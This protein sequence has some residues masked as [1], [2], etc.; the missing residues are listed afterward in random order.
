MLRGRMTTLDLQIETEVR[1]RK[2]QGISGDA[3]YEMVDSA[4]EKRHSSGGI[5][6]DV[7]CGSGHLWR[8]VQTRFARYVGVDIVRYEGF[9]PDAEFH[10]LNLDTGRV[11]LPDGCADVVAAVETI[12]HLENPRACIRELTR[13]LRPGGWL[14]VTTP[15]QLSLLSKLTLV[16]KN[17][18]NAFQDALYPAHITALLEVD[19]ERMARECDL[20]EIGIGYSLHG[21]IPASAWHFPRV[22][23]SQFPRCFSDNIGLIAKKPDATPRNRI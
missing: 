9:P 21:R 3:I 20:T 7:G 18:F 13:L 5:L 16:L 15:N 17:R 1:A 22:L 19:L 12:E 10:P 4:L 2:S 14:V 8:F 11:P 23:S 6:L